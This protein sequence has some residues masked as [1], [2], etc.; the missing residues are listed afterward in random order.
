MIQRVRFK[1]GDLVER[2]DNPSVIGIVTNQINNSSIIDVF[3]PL[4]K[5][6]T[7]LSEDYLNRLPEGTTLLITQ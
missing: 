3:F 6:V 7:Y 2:K 1:V 4:N 5:T